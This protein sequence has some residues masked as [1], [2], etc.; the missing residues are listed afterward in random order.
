MTAM[1]TG[2]RLLGKCARPKSSKLKGEPPKMFP[3]K[4]FSEIKSENL[5]LIKCFK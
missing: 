1:Y 3:E 2:H 5:A 4:K